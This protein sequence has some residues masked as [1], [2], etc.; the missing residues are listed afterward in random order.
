M[1]IE[2]EIV[3][4]VPGTSYTAATIDRRTRTT[5]E[6]TAAPGGS[7]VRVGSRF[8]SSIID[9]ILGNALESRRGLSS[10]SSLARRSLTRLSEVLATAG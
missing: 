9:G 7:I 2:S 6:V 10:Y 5:T 4:M 8:V 1:Q 3:D